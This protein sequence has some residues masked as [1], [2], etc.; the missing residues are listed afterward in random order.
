MMR[1]P[2]CGV[3]AV[4]RVGRGRC[5]GFFLVCAAEAELIDISA[6]NKVINAF[7]IF[8]KFAGLLPVSVRSMI[9]SLSR[10]LRPLTLEQAYGCASFR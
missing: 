4:S 9:L 3:A 7:M 6:I 2:G 8:I 10:R 5:G 1:G